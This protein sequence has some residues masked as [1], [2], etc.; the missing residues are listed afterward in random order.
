M[1]LSVIAMK[2]ATDRE[3]AYSNNA[4]LESFEAHLLLGISNTSILNG[5][6]SQ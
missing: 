3:S 2:H 1:P 6:I 4:L 5:T